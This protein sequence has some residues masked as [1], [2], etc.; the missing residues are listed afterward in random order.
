[1]PNTPGIQSC[2]LC[3]RE[4]Q[5][6][7]PEVPRMDGDFRLRLVGRPGTPGISKYCE[8]LCPKCRDR[9]ERN[10]LKLLNGLQRISTTSKPCKRGHVRKRLPNGDAW[11]PTCQQDRDRRWLEKNP[12]QRAIRAQ[13]TKDWYQD[14]RV[15]FEQAMEAVRTL[16]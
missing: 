16:Q 10:L 9:L 15:A 14:K 6:P 1:M 4:W 8:H 11:C 13:R 3:R 5:N 7:A 2:S 12:H